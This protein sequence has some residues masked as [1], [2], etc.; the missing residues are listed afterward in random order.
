MIVEGRGLAISHGA[1]SPNALKVLRRLNKSG[2]RAF[3]VG[4]SVRDI[5]LGIRPKDFDIATNA[6]PLE[7]QKLFKNSRLIG[8]RFLLV[9]VFFSNEIVEVSTFRS[10]TSIFFKKTSR[11]KKKTKQL[12]NNNAYGTLEEDASCRDFTVNALYYDINN[13][14][15]IDF[16]NGMKDLER[17]LIRMIGNP[18]QR[19]HEDPIRLLRA[20]RL[21]A[22]LNF[23]IHMDTKKPLL[24]L[25]NLLRHVPRTRL[26]AELLKMFCVGHAQRS[27]QLLKY[28][29]Y[30]GML[31]PE[32]IAFLERN[33]NANYQNLIEYS[34][35]SI[36][37][38]YYNK[39]TLNPGFLLAIFL[40]P[41]VQETVEKHFQKDKKLFSSFYYGINHT[42]YLQ[43]KTLAIPRRL[44]KMIRSIWLLQYHLEQQSYNHV[45]KVSQER[46][47]PAALN[48]LELRE[49]TG[50][51]LTT[52]VYW[53]RIFLNGNTKQREQLINK[54]K[55]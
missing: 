26:F 33:Q 37:E 41:V 16:T 55:G 1:I 43:K 21:A 47:F 13:F 8:K 12:T 3:L 54:L 23:K 39:Q 2:Y 14:S 46:F 15:I 19:Y 35:K 25:H 20:V 17:G 11:E 6:H 4:G 5:L 30:M 51:P 42:L 28:T 31:F 9:H 36:D 40:W 38:R 22:K 32:M 53:W 18:T 34:L 27:Y 24:R 29:N 45:Y 49:R 50:E 10:N 48:F 7:I 52:I 44:M